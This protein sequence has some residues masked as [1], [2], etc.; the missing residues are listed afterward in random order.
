MFELVPFNR[1]D[2]FEQSGGLNMVLNAVVFTYM[3]VLAISGIPSDPVKY[4]ERKIMP[5]KMGNATEK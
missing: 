3:P 1:L 4:H 2:F 5:S